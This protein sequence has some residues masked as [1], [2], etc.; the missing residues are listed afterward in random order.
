M[1]I[2]YGRLSDCL[3]W[4]EKGARLKPKDQL[5][6]DQLSYIDS[7]SFSKSETPSGL[8]DE[9]GEPIMETRVSV[10]VGSISKQKVQAL[11]LLAQ[12]GGLIVDPKA[13]GDVFNNTQNNLIF[14]AEWG[15]GAAIKTIS[16]KKR[17]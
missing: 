14:V 13:G 12:I 8:K 6:D 2:A 17:P 3:D 4:D 15:T 9:D 7:I 10:S 16:E 5:T 11:K 1:T